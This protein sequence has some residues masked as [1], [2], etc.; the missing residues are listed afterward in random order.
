VI[1]NS[2]SHEISQFADGINYRNPPKE[3]PELLMPVT[4]PTTP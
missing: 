2:D 4:T 1:R 3:G